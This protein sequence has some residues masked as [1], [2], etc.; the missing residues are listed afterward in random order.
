[1]HGSP[2]GVMASVVILDIIG[3][4]Y[5][6]F[7]NIATHFAKMNSLLILASAVFS[8]PLFLS[9]RLKSTLINVIASTTFGI[10]PLH[11]NIWAREFLWQ[12]VFHNASYTESGLLPIHSIAV[13]LA[14]FAACSLIELLRIKYIE[15]LVFSRLGRGKGLL[16][17]LWNSLSG[18]LSE[19]YSKFKTATQ[20]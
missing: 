16:Y 14:V 4:R 3:I 1:M 7:G 2:W 10:Y 9:F 6:A 13:S 12:R 11:D 20:P 5:P 19:F 17:K 15:A 18:L 8:L